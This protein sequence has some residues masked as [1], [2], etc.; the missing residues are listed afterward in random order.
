M[1]I[2][3]S[4]DDF[5]SRTLL[6]ELLKNYGSP[7][8]VVNG[9][10]AVEA[11]RLSLEADEPYDLIYLDIM[12]PEVDGQQAL[13]VIGRIEKANVNGIAGPGHAKIIM[14]NSL[15]D[16]DNVIKAIKHQCDDFLVKP[17]K[18]AKPLENLCKLGLI[19]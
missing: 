18:N 11:V 13:Q 1:K 12:M 5:T 17:I 16:R 14:T 19:K 10:E 6:Q 4:E 9:M 2:L 8:I 15:G 3:I 7:H